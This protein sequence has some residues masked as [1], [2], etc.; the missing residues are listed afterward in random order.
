MALSLECINDLGGLLGADKMINSSEHT[1]NQAGHTLKR[2]GWR[3]VMPRSRH[4]KKASE[5][6]I[7]ASKK[8]TLDSEK[9]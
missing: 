2:Q 6:A 5:E 8:I 7:E 3:S 1:A 9:Q 4:P